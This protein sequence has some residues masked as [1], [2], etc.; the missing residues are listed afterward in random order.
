MSIVESLKWVLGEEDEISSDK[1]PVF[2]LGV[3]QFLGFGKSVQYGSKEIPT[4]II[5]GQTL[6]SHKIK[7]YSKAIENKILYEPELLRDFIGQEQAKEQIKT[8]VKIIQQ[9]RP[10]NML[11]NGW[12]GCGKT[13]LARITAKMLN[14]NF[15][16]RVPEQLDDVDK[17][18]EVI[19]F[20]QSSETLTVFM[21]D[22]IHSINQFPK[23]ANVLLPILQDW[24]FGNADIRPFVMI[25][26]TTD[27]DQLLKKQGA[28]VSRFQIQITLDK[29]QPKELQTIVKN[30]KEASYKN[31][32]ISE[33]D[34]K[35][36]ARNSRG[37]PREAI[38]L[39]LKQL[40]TQDI[41]K[42]LKQSDIIKD[43]LTKVDLRILKT[44][45]ANSK[46]M[47]ASYLSQATGI[48]Q[49]DYEQIY[50]R[51]LV[52]M[53]YVYRHSRGRTISDK[54]KDLLNNMEA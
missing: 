49:S 19:N 6:E 24:K 5:K 44:L 33:K 41:D 17:L 35:I 9:L 26:A 23:V 7:S 14:A 4:V 51:F 13:T 37:I 31:H 28:L 16:Y 20:I 15:I 47:G 22:E 48:T 30:Y 18:L 21:I 32:S 25:G 11:I 53:G 43:G 34:F 54:G 3:E 40:V 46:P 52:E 36:I 50:E 29:Y 1:K 45:V 42:V 38:A 8:A 2:D 12:P 27:K 10:V 39:L